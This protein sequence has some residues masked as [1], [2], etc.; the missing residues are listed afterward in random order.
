MEE[1]VLLS[2]DQMQELKSRGVDIVRYSMG[3]VYKIAK[4]SMYSIDYTDILW[5]E[6]IAAFNLQDCLDVLPKVLQTDLG[7]YTLVIYVAENRICY[8]PDDGVSPALKCTTGPDLLS[9]A[10]EMI[11][12]QAGV[13]L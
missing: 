3:P 13:K 8:V 12:W 2:V 6:D 11:I 5:S 9:A 1:K 4:G 7:V 10:Y